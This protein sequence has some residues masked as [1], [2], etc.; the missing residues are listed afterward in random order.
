[1]SHEHRHNVRREE[2]PAKVS[3]LQDEYRKEL[4]GRFRDLRGVLRETIVENDALSIKGGRTN[5]DIEAEEEFDFEQNPAKQVEFRN[6]LR[7]W[8]DKGILEPMSVRE[9]EEG[10]HYTSIYVD[11]AYA[12]GL[13]M[14]EQ[15]LVQRGSDVPDTE[16][17][18][19]MSAPIHIDELEILYTRNYSG[20]EDIGKDIEESLSSILTQ[21]LREGWGTTKT[22]NKIN[23]EVGDIQR[24]RSRTFVRTEMLNSH[25][26]ATLKRY[27]GY[28]VETVEILTHT[29]CPICE[30]IEANDPY[31]ITEAPALPLDTH[32]NCQCTYAP[33]V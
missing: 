4:F 31:P 30:R 15:L 19:L 17:T 32:P 24:T 2:S 1:M 8:I 11:A 25:N 12:Q 6:Q 10:N 21:S 22:A 13:G 28:G 23:A 18:Q 3:G 7:E 5:D 27:G 20:L 9:V 33:V 14:A 29:P 16:A 26:T